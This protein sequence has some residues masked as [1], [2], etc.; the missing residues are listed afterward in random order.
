M[1]SHL[2]KTIVRENRKNRLNEMDIEASV[3]DF[4][5]FLKKTRLHVGD[6]VVFC[7]WENRKWELI[8]EVAYVAPKENLLLIKVRGITKPLKVTSLKDFHNFRIDIMDTN[9]INYR[10][11]ERFAKIIE[12]ALT[13]NY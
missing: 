1:N 9:H 13:K 10:I 3:A 2:Q 6:L 12:K 8:G 11:S 5:R 7:S 4:W